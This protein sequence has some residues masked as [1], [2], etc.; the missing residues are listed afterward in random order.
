MKLFYLTII[1]VTCCGLTAHATT[2]Y[3]PGTDLYVHSSGGG[4]KIAAHPRQ[5][6]KTKI[7]RTDHISLV[8]NISFEALVEVENTNGICAC[9]QKYKLRQ[10]IK[11]FKSM[12][13]NFDSNYQKNG[14]THQHFG[15]DKDELKSFNKRACQRYKHRF[16]GTTV[17][18]LYGEYIGPALKEK[19]KS[20]N[21][22]FNCNESPIQHVEEV[23]NHFEGH[24][25]ANKH[26]LILDSKVIEYC[27]Q[28]CG[29]YL[30]SGKT[31]CLLTDLQP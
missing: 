16:F 14:F 20:F 27:N 23:Q 13:G 25:A 22:I 3:C 4:L 29:S 6:V 17:S 28:Q 24:G 21:P 2:L 26:Y 12:D 15:V 11:L 19:K 18:A 7:L 30:A 8:P 5:G 9:K 31:H 1:L 10:A